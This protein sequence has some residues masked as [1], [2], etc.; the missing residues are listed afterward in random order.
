MRPW[1]LL[2]IPAL[3]LAAQS[4][5]PGTG[6]VTGHVY[7][8]DTNAPTRGAHVQL[9]SVRNAEERAKDHPN[10]P[11]GVPVGGSVQTGIDGS[12]TL[13]D[14]LPG[15]YYV[16]ATA[17]GYLSPRAA[18]ADIDNAEP[19][20][21]PGRPPIVI[22]KVDVEPDQTAN[23]DVRLE[24]GA[25]V[26]GTIRFDDGTPAS[27]IHVFV[28]HKTKNKWKGT[29]DRGV[30][31]FSID[32]TDDLGHYRIRGL[33]DSEYIVEAVFNH[34]EFVHHSTFDLT[35]SLEATS[36]LV[37]YSGD[38]LER[39]K[40]VAFKL[41]P[42]EERT[43]EDITI[44]LSKLHTIRGAVVATGSGVSMTSGYVAIQ[45]ANG[46]S[47]IADTQIRNDGTF[48]LAA[49]PE[50]TYRIHVGSPGV[51]TNVKI[52]RAQNELGI[53]VNR[54]VH[55]YADLEQTIKIE[56]DISNLILAVPEQK[57]EQKK[58]PAATP[59]Q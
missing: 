2:L 58:Q 19:Q 53:S 45:D 48:Y 49:V 59:S 29:R 36:S 18:G 13:S 7:C 22:P 1:P 51:V 24:R 21:L 33:R 11:G 47:R 8:A 16:V 12:F 17:D 30:F 28:L 9:E 40:A 37:V 6:A 46:D 3:T 54:S 50:G 42:G 4:A 41:S 27:G 44:P 38:A 56:G 32:Q 20:P 35:G 31:M 14:V 10:F 26:S 25:A 43:G 5:R 39:S 15:A 23:I 55:P 57:N 52:G 34:T